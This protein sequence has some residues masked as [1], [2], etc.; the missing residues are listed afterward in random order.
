MTDLVKIAGISILIA[1]LW[2]ASVA[3]TYWDTHRRD[4]AGGH[5]FAWLALV[6]LLPLV[7][8]LAYLLLR[9]F[10]HIFA[11]VSPGAAL[12]PRRE[13]A[14]KPPP[15][16]P[17]GK[18]GHLPTLLAPDPAGQPALEAPQRGPLGAALGAA[19]DLAKPAPACILTIASG[20][21]PVREMVID[22][23]PARIGRG[24]E[25]SI[26]LDAD[27]GVSRA[28]AE[29]YERDG[30]LRIRDLDS[31]HG[32]RVNGLRIE[33]SRLAPGDRIQMGLSV[34]VVQRTGG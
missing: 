10:D 7:G 23:L 31:T 33:D 4:L 12:E 29:L 5:S 28:H 9:A 24:P 11:P 32:T 18:P 14:L 16:R 15:G 27:L 17:A 6:A 1:A 13:T 21:G 25:A 22:R 20:A 26:R 3:F 8:F 30:T 34:L 19:L 2:A